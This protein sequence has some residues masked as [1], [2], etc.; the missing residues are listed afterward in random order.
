VYIQAKRYQSTNKIQR[1]D[2][3]GFYGALKRIHA[4]RGVF[5]TTSGFS[6]AA[7]E[8]AKGFSIVLIDGIKLTDLMLQYNVGVRIE[9]TY[10]LYEIDEDFFEMDWN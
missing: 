4:D 6:K 8:A 7:E 2:I 9:A 3:E 1:Q 5:I 10:A